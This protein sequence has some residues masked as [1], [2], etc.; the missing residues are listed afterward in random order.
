[1]E[2]QAAT[3]ASPAAAT[4]APHAAALRLLV[5][6]DDPVHRMV[7]GK[8][9]EKAGYAVSTATTVEEAAERITQERFDCISLDLALGGQSGSRMLHGIA[10]A[11]GDVMLIVI[12]SAAIEVRE[13][14]IES[15]RDLRLRVVEMPKPVDLAGL[16]ARLVGHAGIARL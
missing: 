11:N 4:L 15:A 5:I 7:I 8:V 13:E 14:A 10:R 9:G 6:D 12:N 3:V 16:R 2:T 1:M